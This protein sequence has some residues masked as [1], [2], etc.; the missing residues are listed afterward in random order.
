MFWPHRS[1]TLTSRIETISDLSSFRNLDFLFLSSTTTTQHQ[2]TN[3][4]STPLSSINTLPNT[5][6]TSSINKTLKMPARWDDAAEK[7]LLLCVCYV[8][9]ITSPDWNKVAAMMGS[10]YTA[11]A[12][13]Q[14]P[15]SPLSL[16]TCPSSTLLLFQLANVPCRQKF[17][18]IKKAIKEQHGDVN[19]DSAG[20]T[21]A[22]TP[23]SG[24][25]RGRPKKAAGESAKGK[26][27]GGKKG[28]EDF[29]A[30]D[31][32]DDFEESP[33]KKVKKEESLEEDGDELE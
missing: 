7:Q 20:G 28:G 1:S 2:A 29:D 6:H 17:A 5:Q 15:S 19:G 18:K 4:S 24:A 3:H 21:P 30:E 27:A 9:N 10:D 22:P 14:V 16:P 12:V 25:K 11:S 13:M 26:G 23:K 33:T 8:Q 32:Q 31:D